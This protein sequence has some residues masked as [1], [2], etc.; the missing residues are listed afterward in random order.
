MAPSK[1]NVSHLLDFEVKKAEV[2]GRSE[3]TY[4]QQ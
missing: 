3:T 4:G 1:R 2:Q